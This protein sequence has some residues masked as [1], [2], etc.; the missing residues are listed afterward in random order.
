M[1]KKFYQHLTYEQRCQIYA[2]LKRNFSFRQIAI[3]INVAPSTVSREV[4]RNSGG[5]GYRYKQAQ[6]HRDWRREK[7]S[8]SPNKITP[9]LIVFINEKLNIQW[10]PEQISGYLKFQQNT[11]EI[12][13]TETIYKLIRK[14]KKIGGDIYKNL[15]HKG[16][17][18]RKSMKISAGRGLIP[19]RVDIEEREE[20]VEL[21]QRVGDWECDTIIGAEHKGAIVSVVDRASKLVK[22]EKSDTKQSVPVSRRIIKMLKN[23][24][25]EVHTLTYDNGA[26][27]AKH[28][29]INKELCS[30]SYFAKPYRSWERGLNEHTNGLVR[31]YIPKGTKFEYV[32]KE[33]LAEI[34]DLL[35]NRP[36]KVLNYMT[37]NEKFI[38]LTGVFAGVALRC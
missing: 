33:M 5:S 3:D 25:K 1:I 21:K 17:K 38:E 31:Q 32:S 23:I 7:A 36:R 12:I 37:P 35:N 28:V 22:L 8:N 10:S 27:F 11:L 30:K 6:N 20:I 15:R 9:E 34:E 18:Y 14:D 16:K 2:L 29:E 24:K 13:S 26:E 4:F 19:N